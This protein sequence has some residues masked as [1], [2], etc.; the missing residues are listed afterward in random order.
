MKTFAFVSTDRTRV[1][2][3]AS[4]YAHAVRV[5]ALW[6]ETRHDQFPETLCRD[7]WRPPEGHSQHHLDTALALETTGVG[8]YDAASGWAILAPDDVASDTGR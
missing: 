1:V 8:Y 3:F 2:V 5:Y 7:V 4:S 6:F